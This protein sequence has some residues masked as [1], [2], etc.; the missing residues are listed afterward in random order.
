MFDNTPYLF[1]H[2][3]DASMGCRKA[4]LKAK[5]ERDA[6]NKIQASYRRYV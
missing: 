5:L 1:I 4:E 3:V 6:A 2:T